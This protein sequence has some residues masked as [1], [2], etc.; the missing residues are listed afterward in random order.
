MHSLGDG[1][2]HGY[3]LEKGGLHAIVDRAGAKSTFAR[4]KKGGKANAIATAPIPT[5]NEPM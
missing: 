1:L 4:R 2:A 3:L 5:A